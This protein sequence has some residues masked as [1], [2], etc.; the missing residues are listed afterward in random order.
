MKNERFV[1]IGLGGIG[2]I[3][4]EILAKYCNYDMLNQNPNFKKIESVLIDGDYYE[5]KNQNRQFFEKEGLEKNKAYVKTIELSN[6]YPLIEFNPIDKFINEE[7]ISEYIRENDIVFSC[8]DQHNTRKII[9]DW[10]SKLNDILLISGGNEL[11]T[12]TVQ[13]Y[14]RKEG[15]DLTPKI[16]K[17]HS[18][19]ENP[20]DKHP[21]DMSC[22]E[23]QNVEP[24]LI[25]TNNYVASMMGAAFYVSYLLEDHESSEIRG[26]IKTMNVTSQYLKP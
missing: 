4:V 26:D 21:E 1:F 2:S 22:E 18:E 11:T 13:I 24:Q 6:K 19:I 9:S 7:N 5:F 20:K 10:V 3:L 12:T 16:T 23:L 17:Y 25:F 8:V 14:L 15:K